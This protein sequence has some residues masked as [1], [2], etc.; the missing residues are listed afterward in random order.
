MEEVT[1]RSCDAAKCLERL[2]AAGKG[3]LTSTERQSFMA[4]IKDWLVKMRRSLGL[5]G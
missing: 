5:K 4:R 1:G 2:Y 3:G